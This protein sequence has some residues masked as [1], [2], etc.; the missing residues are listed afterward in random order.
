MKN[1]YW[2]LMAMLVFGVTSIQAHS[3]AFRPKFVDC[4]A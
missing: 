3:E 4:L 1:Y 2:I